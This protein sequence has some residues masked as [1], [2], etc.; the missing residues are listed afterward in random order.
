MAAHLLAITDH[1]ADVHL[2]HH[3]I[4][5]TGLKLKHTKS[6]REIEAFLL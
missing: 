4:A 5:Q 1:T 3:V 2:A 6:P